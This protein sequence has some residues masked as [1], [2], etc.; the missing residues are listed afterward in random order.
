MPKK[1]IIAKKVVHRLKMKQN[2]NNKLTNEDSFHSLE[3]P[4]NK[5][6]ISGK[7]FS[8]IFLFNESIFFI[9]ISRHDHF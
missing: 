3:A 9:P 4:S 7:H 2:K 8:Q 5:K 6:N 1:L